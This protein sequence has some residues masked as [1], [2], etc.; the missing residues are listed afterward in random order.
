MQQPTL[1]DLG[2]W[3]NREVILEDLHQLDSLEYTE[4]MMPKYSSIFNLRDLA[5]SYMILPIDNLKK[6]F[7]YRMIQVL[8]LLHAD[9]R[10]TQG[11]TTTTFE[12][13][14]SLLTLSRYNI[15][16]KLGEG[17]AAN[18]RSIITLL[19]SILDKI[20]TD[21]EY[22]KYFQPI[23]DS[24]QY[25]LKQL[26][27]SNP[28]LI[29]HGSNKWTNEDIAQNIIELISIYYRDDLIDEIIHTF[30]STNLI[31]RE[32]SVVEVVQPA[33]LLDYFKFR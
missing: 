12:N 8:P 14:I 25:H 5:D 2:R 26:D 7:V 6:A 24:I 29:A 18:S 27:V 20:D 1:Q 33:S 19:H 21:P 3:I 28:S 4:V 16:E 15:L 17:T 31:N 30:E 13:F 10:A 32:T 9:E 22:V 11:S 23:I